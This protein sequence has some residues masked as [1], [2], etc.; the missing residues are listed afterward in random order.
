[1]LPDDRVTVRPVEAS[2]R[3]QLSNIIHFEA[4]VH[5]HL[6]WRPPLEWIGF[7]PFLVALRNNQIIAALACPPDPPGVAWVRVFVSGGNSSYEEMWDLLWSNTQTQLLEKNTNS[8]AAI[9]LQKWFRELIHDKGFHHIHNVIVFAWDDIHKELPKP[10][11]IK[12]RGIQKEDLPIIQEIDEEA[13][14]PIWR[15]SLDS[16]ILAFKQSKLATVVEDQFGLVGYQISTPT[17]YG[18]HLA[19]LAVRPRAQGLGIGYA[20]VRHLQ[21]QLKRLQP[22]RISVNTQDHNHASIALYKKAGFHQVDEAYPVFQYEF[23][24]EVI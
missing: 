15:N 22:L 6:D 1:M 16:L 19:R 8:I 13:F 5:R 14:G 10:K 9:P 11:S 18:A 4:R 23:G 20:L 17:P 21:D 3:N 24:V 12:I 2:D 7:Q